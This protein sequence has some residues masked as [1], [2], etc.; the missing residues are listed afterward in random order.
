MRL[1]N[2]AGSAV[3]STVTD[4]MGEYVFTGLTPGSYHVE[5]DIPDDRVASPQDV[6]ADDELDS[7]I[8]PDGVMAVTTLDPSEDDR[9]W[10]A[11]LHV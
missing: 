11:G 6:G 7:D 8:D 4:G 1:L 3:R 9:R 2:G 5:V 10:D